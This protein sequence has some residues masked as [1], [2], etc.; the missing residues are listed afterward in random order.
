[1]ITR[2]EV[3][4]VGAAAAAIASANGLG[5]VGHAATRERLS[6][7]ELLRFDS[8][9][10]IT[11]LH[12]ADLHGQLM[13]VYFRE[14]SVNIGVGEARG[15]PPHLTGRDFLKKFGIPPRTAAA[16]A[17]M[18]ELRRHAKHTSLARAQVSTLREH[19]FKLSARIEESVRR[20]VVHLPQSFP[21]AHQWSSLARQLGA[22]APS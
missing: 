22:A 10:N 5:S 18:Q 21:Y 9:G 14:P 13:P 11:L 12:I 3:F 19:L 20:I 1:M 16:Y 4:Q 17:L 6:E 15:Q 8:V 7:Q 2:R